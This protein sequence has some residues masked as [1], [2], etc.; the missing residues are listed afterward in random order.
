MIVLLIA[1]L[2]LSPSVASAEAFLMHFK[3]DF[4]AYITDHIIGCRRDR[5]LSSWTLVTQKCRVPINHT[6][7]ITGFGVVVGTATDIDEVDIAINSGGVMRSESRINFADTAAESSCDDDNI[8]GTLDAAGEYCFQVVNLTIPASNLYYV[9]VVSGVAPDNDVEM[10]DIWLRGTLTEDDQPK[11]QGIQVITEQRLIYDFSTVDGAVLGYC[12]QNNSEQVT[13]ILCRAPVD[14]KIK[15]NM[16][17]AELLSDGLAGVC[18]RVSIQVGGVNQSLYDIYFGNESFQSVENTEA[19][20]GNPADC[21]YPTSTSPDTLNKSG[22]SCILRGNV[23]VPAGDS[24][25]WSF[26]DNPTPCSTPLSGVH[27]ASVFMEVELP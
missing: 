18:G 3:M 10:A 15:A 21:D 6:L 8:T 23:D 24:Y 19:G 5:M 26:L 13:G 22:E 17:A 25:G 9:Q 12:D 2:F 1:L 4:D 27:G 7:H 14:V 16:M 20:S 11:S